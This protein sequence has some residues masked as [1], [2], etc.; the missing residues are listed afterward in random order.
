MNPSVDNLCHSLYD[1][2]NRAID[3]TMNGVIT[4]LQPIWNGFR[5]NE[6]STL[7]ALRVRFRSTPRF[8]YFNEFDGVDWS[9]K[10]VC[11]CKE[12]ILKIRN[13]GLITECNGMN[14]LANFPKQPVG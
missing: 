14:N 4:G 2:V 12:G 10:N 7:L 9:E 8:S 6:F 3:R 1:A 5:T 13:L 11:Y